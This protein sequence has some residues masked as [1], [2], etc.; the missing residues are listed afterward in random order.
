MYIKIVIKNLDKQKIVGNGLL[1]F[2][3]ET[4]YIAILDFFNEV[5]DDED[6]PGLPRTRDEEFKPFIRKLPEFKF[7]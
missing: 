5:S 4:L 3:H 7:W 1:C 2:I 6:E